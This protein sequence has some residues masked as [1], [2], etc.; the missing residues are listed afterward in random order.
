MSRWVDADELR[1]ELIKGHDLVGAKYVDLA[2]TIEPCEDAISRAEAISA[3]Y[4]C[5]LID[6]ETLDTI[7]STEAI[8]RL[9]AVRKVAPS[10]SGGEWIPCSE[11]LP[12]EVKASYWICTDGEHQCECR[13][14][15]ANPFWTDLTTDWHWN[16]YDIPQFNKVVAWMPLPEPWKGAD[17]E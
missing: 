7:H 3:I 17:D 5:E 9:F 13:W 15:N 6:G 8:Q 12:E 14:T 11:R 1:S 10:R 2:S 4:E 16:I